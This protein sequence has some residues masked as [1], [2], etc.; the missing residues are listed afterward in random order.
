VITLVLLIISV[1]IISVIEL[2]GLIKDQMRRE[3]AVFCGLLA[4]GIAYGI[5]HLLKLDF[6]NPTDIT[7]YIFEPIF[8][9]VDGFLK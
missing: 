1:V 9:A 5:I 3:L 7:R 6:L 8:K 2:P 4:I